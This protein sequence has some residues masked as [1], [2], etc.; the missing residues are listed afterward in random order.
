M[1]RYSLAYVSNPRSLGI[2]AALTIVVTT[3]VVSFSLPEFVNGRHSWFLGT[4]DVVTYFQGPLPDNYPHGKIVRP[5]NCRPRL[6][7]KAQHLGYAF[8][9]DAC[10]VNCV[11]GET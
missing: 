4:D 3:L 8:D 6:R 1:D 10:D 2:R 7:P 9:I 5:A 11:N